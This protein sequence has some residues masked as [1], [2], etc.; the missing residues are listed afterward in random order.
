MIFKNAMSFKT[1]IKQLAKEKGITSQQVQ[2]NY[3]IEVFLVK[4][5][6]SK[7]KDNFII[8]GGYLIGGIVCRC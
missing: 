3:L 4:L 7:Y 2:Q 1:K 5:A 8:K 6:K